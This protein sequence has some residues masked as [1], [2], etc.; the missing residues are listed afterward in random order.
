[1][2]GS[3]FLVGVWIVLQK[4]T[5]TV[6]LPVT[7]PMD[8]CIVCATPTQALRKEWWSVNLG[9]SAPPRPLVSPRMPRGSVDTLPG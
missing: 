2:D 4:T 1:M 7:T 9:D 8:M 3:T 6:P 5:G